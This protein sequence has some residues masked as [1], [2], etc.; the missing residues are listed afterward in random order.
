MVICLPILNEETLL[1]SLNSYLLTVMFHL[2]IQWF[3]ES[4]LYLSS[5]MDLLHLILMIP[6]GFGGAYNLD[7]LLLSALPSKR[8]C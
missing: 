8:E 7:I 4:L 3:L 5:T 6:L 1:Y 2:K